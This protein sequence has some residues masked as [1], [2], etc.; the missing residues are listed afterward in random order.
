MSIYCIYLDKNDG[1]I[2]IV[3]EYEYGQ[4]LKI[5]SYRGKR[6][7]LAIESAL[8]RAGA[9]AAAVAVVGTN[10]NG[11]IAQCLS[12]GVIVEMGHLL[13]V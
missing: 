11:V 5:A 6:E 2:Y 8:Q 1:P 3:S 4:Y 7:V 12:T 10:K 13:R 9:H